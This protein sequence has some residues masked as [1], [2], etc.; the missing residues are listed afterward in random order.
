MRRERRTA[1]TLCLTMALGV[2]GAVGACTDGNKA[3]EAAGD[4]REAGGA[5]GNDSSAAG[6]ARPG[7]SGAL[8]DTLRPGPG[9]GTDT[10]TKARSGAGS[11]TTKRP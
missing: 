11:D 10:T 8:T 9:S 6:Y 4:A 7:T 2:A 3:N 5:P 1:L